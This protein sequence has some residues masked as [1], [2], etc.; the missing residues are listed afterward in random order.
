MIETQFYG[1]M[2]FPTPTVQNQHSEKLLR[3]LLLP[4]MSAGKPVS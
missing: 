2:P 3:L 4:Y 1:W